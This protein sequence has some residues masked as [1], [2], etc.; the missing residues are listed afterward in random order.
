MKKGIIFILVLMFTV[1]WAFAEK[2]APIQYDPADYPAPVRQ[3]GETVDDATVIGSLP[4]NDAGTTVGYVDDYDE[5]CP[6]TGSTSPDVVYSYTPT[7]D[8]INGFVSLCG[9]TDY[10]SKLYIYENTVTPG[11]PFDCVD[12]VCTSALGQSYVSEITDLTFIGGNT[13]YFVVDGYG[14]A[15]GN[16]FQVLGHNETWVCNKNIRSARNSNT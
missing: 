1:S 13:Y 11:A 6:Y 8:V 9:D 10:D 15:S 4:Y 3:G 16:S 14:G 5:V 7:V 12:D 2:G